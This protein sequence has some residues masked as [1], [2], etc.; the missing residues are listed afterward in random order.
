MALKDQIARL[1]KDVAGHKELHS[2]GPLTKEAALAKFTG[3]FQVARLPLP[4]F[5]G[6]KGVDEMFK[7]VDKAIE[8]L[9]KGPVAKNPG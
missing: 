1:K 8:T 2:E 5:A 6:A 3:A 9:A 4:S 7:V